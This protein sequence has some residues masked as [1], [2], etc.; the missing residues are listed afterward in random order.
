MSGKENGDRGAVF[1]GQLEQRILLLDGAMGTMLYQHG[2][3]RIG[4]ILDEMSAW[5][6]AHGFATI[7]DFKG[8]MSQESSAD[9]ASYERVQFMK[10]S[11]AQS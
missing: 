3:S 9:P 7:A 4:S 2:V 6:D 5:M 10:T 1:R 11:E 8:R